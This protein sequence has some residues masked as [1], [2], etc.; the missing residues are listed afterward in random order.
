MSFQSKG[1]IFGERMIGGPVCLGGS[2]ALRRKH[3]FHGNRE[4]LH[5]IIF[6]DHV[7]FEALAF[8]CFSGTAPHLTF[9]CYGYA[10]AALA[11]LTW[12]QVAFV[13]QSS[14]HQQEP[15]LPL[16]ELHGQDVNTDH[17]HP[18]SVSRV[19][20]EIPRGATRCSWRTS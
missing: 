5:V 14:R 13:T 15:T 16:K 9:R 4:A 7:G 2:K 12:R 3:H 1:S 10:P 11:I 8:M 19:F 18:V 20:P 6:P 17:F